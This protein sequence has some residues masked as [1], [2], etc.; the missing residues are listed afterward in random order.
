VSETDDSIERPVDDERATVS[1]LEDR[2]TVAEARL[3]EG[4]IAEEEAESGRES[5][6]TPDQ[7]AE[8][9]LAS[10][11][12][13]G[14]RSPT[15]E[16]E[17]L[18]EVDHVLGSDERPDGNADRGTEADQTE[19]ARERTWREQEW[20]RRVDK[21]AERLRGIDALEPERWRAADGLERQHALRSANAILADSFN[22]P[23]SDVVFYPL[24]GPYAKLLGDELPTTTDG[25]LDVS[26]N[27]EIGNITLDDR[28]LDPARCIEP[29]EALDSLC[30]EY[31]H[32]YQFD[33]AA[34][35]GDHSSPMDD[36]AMGRT[37][38]AYVEPKED[39]DAYENQPVERDSRTFAAEICRAVYRR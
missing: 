23:S 16:R 30:H 33:A 1:D 28:F 35:S 12:E 13:D 26:A 18:D 21:V 14:L 19:G 10:D 39:F 4:D 3:T 2:D 32:V 8:M 9:R 34:E 24:N 37:S 38:S 15:A 17:D 22:E 7:V 27:G 29:E 5:H 11:G 36:G 20:D 25:Q 6:M 31:R